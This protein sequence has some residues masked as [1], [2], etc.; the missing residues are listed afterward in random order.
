MALP[1]DVLFE[2]FTWLCIA[3][4]SK[5][6][7]TCKTIYAYGA[8]A[9]LLHHGLRIASGKLVSLGLFLKADFAR[10]KLPRRLHVDHIPREAQRQK[11]ARL[12]AYALTKATNI[13]EVIA[14]GE[15]L[16]QYR[17]LTT[18]IARMTSI[19]DLQIQFWEWGSESLLAQ[20]QSPIRRLE[21]YLYQQNGWWV[22]KYINLL[23]HLER[24]QDSL[25][26]LF[27]VWS[28]WSERPSGLIFPKVH[29]LEIHYCDS[30]N[31]YPLFAPSRTSK[32]SKFMRTK[33]SLYFHTWKA[34]K[35]PYDCATSPTKSVS[36]H[37][38]TSSLHT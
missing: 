20:I 2:L 11:G 8:H 27:V 4:M 10:C 5:L 29:I 24:L 25:E 14:V 18:A 17:N 3:D 35:G 7:R 32:T 33:N 36:E 9:I 34:V 26:E 16:T 1:F 13:R 15:T 28:H 37:G 12:L 31:S 19:E 38:P 6:M 23:P 22:G 21:V 30:S